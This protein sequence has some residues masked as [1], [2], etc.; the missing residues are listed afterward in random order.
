MTVNV[1]VHYGVD[2][3][4]LAWIASG[5]RSQPDSVSLK[6]ACDLFARRVAAV[7]ALRIVVD[8]LRLA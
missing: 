6:S 4:V 5:G 8:S 3:D 7:E 2:A 1:S